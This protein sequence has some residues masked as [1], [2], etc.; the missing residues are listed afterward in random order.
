[1]ELYVRQVACLCCSHS[2]SFVLH[3]DRE[4]LLIGQAEAAALPKTAAITCGRCG[5][6]SLIQS[7]SDG[8]PY[9][10]NG[11]KG[12]RRRPAAP[13]APLV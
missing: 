11:E 12:R 4:H 7:W 10:T 1:M 6:G 8:I 3:T 13:A 5:S 9:A 2:R